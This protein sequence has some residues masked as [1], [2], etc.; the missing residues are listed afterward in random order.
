MAITGNFEHFQ[1]FN[2]ETNFLK[3]AKPIQK[4]GV[5]LFSWKYED[6]K[7]NISI[8][9][10]VLPATVLSLFFEFKNLKVEIW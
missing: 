5:Q 6:W 2:F 8:Q 1:Y 7:R 10:G 3:N 9:S 4:T